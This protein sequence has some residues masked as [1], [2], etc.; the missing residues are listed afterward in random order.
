H[1]TLHVE[2]PLGALFECR[3]IAGFAVRL[4]AHRQKADP[5]AP[6][7]ER[8]MTSGEAPLSF[9]QQRLW[10]LAQMDPESPL[11]N[12]SLTI[13]LSGPLDAQALAKSFRE[14]VRRHGALRTT[15]AELG[16]GPLQHVS[17]DVHVPY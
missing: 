16:S 17:R 8:A 13:R 6:R 10:F 14:L 2:L 1:E 11:Y 5:S 7:L 4:E 15:F 9:A 3:T 12:I